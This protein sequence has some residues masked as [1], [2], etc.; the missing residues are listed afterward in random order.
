MHQIGVI[1]EG[2]GPCGAKGFVVCCKWQ[3]V[4]STTGGDA[5]LAFTALRFRIR[6]RQS[7]LTSIDIK[8]R[9]VLHSVASARG[10]EAFLTPPPHQSLDALCINAATPR[11][12]ARFD[13]STYDQSFLA[14]EAPL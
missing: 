5:L 10:A 1:S 7:Y 13:T 12:F 14:G 3:T 4:P 2:V 11:P 9:P 8:S 6:H